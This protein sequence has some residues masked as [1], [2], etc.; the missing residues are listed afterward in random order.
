MRCV[1]ALLVFPL[2]L[3]L[4]LPVHAGGAEPASPAEEVVEG[5]TEL[6]FGGVP[7]LNYDAD[8]GFGFGAI[9]TVFFYDKVRKPYRYALTLQV[10]VTSKLVQDHQVRFDAVDLMG[11]PLRLTFRGGYFQT[12]THPFCGFGNAVTCDP[13]IAEKAADARSL[14]GEEREAFVRRYYQVR[15]LRPYGQLNLRWKLN[16]LPNR[17]E[18]MGGWRGHLYLP[19]N[20]VDEDGDGEAD[21]LPYP[22]SLYEQVVAERGLQAGERGLASIVHVGVMLDNRDNEPAPKE[23]YWLEASLR[24]SSILWGSAWEYVGVNVTLRS[25]TPLLADKSLVL[26]NRV[27]L[28]GTAGDLPVQE[29][30]RVGGSWDYTALGGNPMGRGIRLQRI[31]GRIKVLDQTE[32]RWDFLEHEWLGQRFRWSTGAFL[33][34]GWVALDWTDI[35]GDPWKIAFGVG[36]T[37]RVAWNEN[38]VVRLD[39]ATSPEER[40]GIAPYI[41]IGHPF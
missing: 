13:A 6:G 4:A 5:E 28:D 21:L 37:L 18:I 27:V 38:F 23:G 1:P 19:G 17:L 11:L 31:I 14:S 2:G 34:A 12:L 41:D 35:G 33:D 8:N 15:F 30:V 3:A 7:A 26:A 40:W 24:G 39:V 29:M 32:L 36:G 20:W 16:E 25:Y 10:F 9:G 22:G